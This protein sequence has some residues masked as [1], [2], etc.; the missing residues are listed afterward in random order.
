[1][2]DPPDPPPI[3]TPEQ[4]AAANFLCLIANLRRAKVTE[5]QAKKNRINLEELVAK[6]I[7]TDDVGQKTVTASDGTKVTIKRGFNY[8]AD[9]EGV[10]ESFDAMLLAA[11]VKSKTTRELDVKGYE[12][13]RENDR[14]AFCV[15]AKHVTV[16]PK[17]VSVVLK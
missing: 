9:L 2:L 12:W 7:P 16:T 17:K 8:K 1:M 4:E 11:P 13:Y 15:L 10:Q 14:D 5:E 3:L 6:L